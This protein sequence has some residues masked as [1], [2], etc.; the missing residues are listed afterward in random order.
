M[1]RDRLGCCGC[2]GP[3][4]ATWLTPATGGVHPDH[5]RHGID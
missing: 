2:P 5:T 4:N 1:R 3:C